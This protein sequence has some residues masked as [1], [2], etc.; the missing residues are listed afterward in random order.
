MKWL[1]TPARMK[2]FKGFPAFQM[3]SIHGFPTFAE[4]Y[5]EAFSWD[6]AFEFA[7]VTALVREHA[8]P[9]RN[10]MDVGAGTGRF[11]SSI[12]AI[13]DQCC[14]L[15]PDSDMYNCLQDTVQGLGEDAARV[16]PILGYL[17]D[18]VTAERFDLIVAMT[19]TVSYVFPESRL[20]SFF[21]SAADLL[22]DDGLLIVDAGMWAG[23][24]GESRA[25]HWVTR[26]SGS[27]LD[28]D[29]RATVHRE[30][31]DG[32]LA[33]KVETLRFELKSPVGVVERVRVQEQFAFSISS[34]VE[35]AQ[36]A[37]LTFVATAEPGG[38]ITSE[39]SPRIKRAF[40]A[41]R[42]A[43]RD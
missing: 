9:P 37:D 36:M 31:A 18:V 32:M 43:K 7:A 4:L 39:I 17:E 11:L 24:V 6:P 33:R 16:E 21:S 20:R 10:A 23:Y 29:F 8:S 12:L 22:H 40:V 30:A 35:A 19:D 34:L 14:A 15:E 5:A 13:A 2:F 41:F 1:A 3:R 28:A 26:S 27:H 42:H 38:A 25:E